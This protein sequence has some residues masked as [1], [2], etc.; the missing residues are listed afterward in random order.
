MVSLATHVAGFGGT[1]CCPCLL[2]QSA[3]RVIRTGIEQHR[4]VT[5]RFLHEAST[6]N[7]PLHLAIEDVLKGKEISLPEGMSYFDK[8]GHERH[9]MRTKWYESA[10]QK[11]YRS[12]ALTAD[13]DL[14]DV[15]IQES[16]VRLTSPYPPNASPVFSDITG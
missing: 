16:I 13:P 11:T 2:G 10:A 6:K 1:A 4:G 15:P 14:P 3:N 9:A 8:D 5:S 7:G 12:Y